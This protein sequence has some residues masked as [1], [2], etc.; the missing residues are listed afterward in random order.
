[1]DKKM[2]L[3][4]IGIITYSRIEFL[5]KTIESLKRNPIAIKSQLYIFVDGPKDGDNLKVHNVIEYANTIDGF[6]RVTV[7]TRIGNNRSDNYFNGIGYLLKKYKKVI[8]LEDDNI[9]SSQFLEYMNSGLDYYKDNMNILAICGYNPPVEYATKYKNNDHYLSSYFNAWGYATW[10]NRETLEIEKI[11]SQY[12][13]L[14][15]NR[16]LYSKIKRKHPRLI[17]GLK[18]INDRKL[19]AGDYRI[20]F[21]LIKNDCYVVKPI[22]SYVNN[23]GHDGSGVHCGKTNKYDNNVINYSL[24]NFSKNIKYDPS[25]DLVWRRFMD[26]KDPIITRVLRRVKVMMKSSS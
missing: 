20:T 14:L 16:G 6:E 4:P 23:I 10:A 17:G 21:H 11:N 9:V 22:I 8:F 5:K 13:E 26:K 12:S 1:M 24:V 25:L 18:L 19:N 3:A 7:S 2:D 15:S